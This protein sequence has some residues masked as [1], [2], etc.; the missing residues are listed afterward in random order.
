MLFHD[1][2]GSDA[3][4]PVV[5]SPGTQTSLLFSIQQGEKHKATFV[6]SSAF[7][8]LD[9]IRAHLRGPLFHDLIDNDHPS[10]LPSHSRI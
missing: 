3:S 4:H 8:L 9:D 6:S 2:N 1:W 7:I 5:V 10:V